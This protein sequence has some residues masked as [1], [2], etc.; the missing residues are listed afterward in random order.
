MTTL[1]PKRDDK[2][3]SRRAVAAL[4][5]LGLAAACAANEPTAGDTGQIRKFADSLFAQGEYFRAATE[6]LRLLSYAPDRPD[7]ADVRLVVALCSYKAGRFDEAGEK[8]AH[9][10]LSPSSTDY[11][12][13]CILYAAASRYRVGAFAEAHLLASRAQVASPQSQIRDR[14]AYLDG[15]SLM[16]SG[17]WKAAAE[18]FGKVSPNSGLLASAADLK[19]LAERA[20]N[21]PRRN[22]WITAGLSVL[23]PGLGS[24]AC[25]Y[26]WDALTALV[27]TGASV[28]LAA[29]GHGRGNP[30]VESGGLVLSCLF[31]SANIYGGAGAAR[32]YNAAAARRV[33]EKTDALSTLSLD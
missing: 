11:R 4:L 8:F 12:D 31:Y 27:L 14:F 5:S 9:L 33:R 24:A 22:P 29:G 18:S 25:G 15:L 17:A 13:T 1:S 2:P 32:R 19:N 30:W 16:H 23:V 10:A 6:Y 21:G 26:H 3:F 28:A 7:S 20:G